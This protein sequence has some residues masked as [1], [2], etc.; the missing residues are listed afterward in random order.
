MDQIN[1]PQMRVSCGKRQGLLPSGLSKVHFGK[2][3]Q[4]QIISPTYFTCNEI[5]D[6]CTGSPAQTFIAHNDVEL[7]SYSDTLS[8]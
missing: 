7:A 1:K 3:N 6:I 8:F 2:M 4:S 5:T